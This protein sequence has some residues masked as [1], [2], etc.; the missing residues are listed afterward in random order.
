MHVHDVLQVAEVA[1]GPRGI[2][3]SYVVDVDFLP[4]DDD[5]VRLENFLGEA[6]E[7]AAI[8]RTRANGLEA[9]TLEGLKELEEGPFRE[10][11]IELLLCHRGVRLLGRGARVN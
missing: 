8:A 5:L 3:E 6:G 9:A 7:E 1:R 11:G 4:A 10:L 2:L